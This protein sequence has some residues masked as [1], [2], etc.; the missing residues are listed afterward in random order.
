MHSQAFVSM[1][2]KIGN[3]LK[4]IYSVEKA[5]SHLPSTFYLLVNLKN[6]NGPSNSEEQVGLS[7]TILS[8]LLLEVTT[9]VVFVFIPLLVFIVLS[10]KCVPNK[11]V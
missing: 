8:S 11:N 5:Y 6:N 7:L 2:F 1:L 9:I 3:E 10:Y 4:N